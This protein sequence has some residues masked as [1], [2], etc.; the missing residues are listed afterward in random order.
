M[1]KAIL[2][3][4]TIH[5]ITGLLV[6]LLT[7]LAEKNTLIWLI[8]GG[9]LFA[10]VTFPLKKFQFLHKT[11]ENSYG[12]LFYPLGVLSAFL[13]LF[14]QPIYLF[15]VSI[16]LLTVSDTLAN[17]L[18][19]LSS[20][21]ITFRIGKDIKSINGALA[22][23][24]SGGL[25]LLAFFPDFSQID[26]SWIFLLLFGLLNF[27]LISFK[28]SDNLTIPLGS[29]ILLMVQQ[30]SVS[31]SSHL[32][33]T[34]TIIAIGSIF[35][36]KMR[37][38]SRYGSLLAY[39]LGIYFA[40]FHNFQWILP[41]LFFLITSV[42]FTRLNHKIRKKSTDSNPRNAWQVGANILPAIVV[43]FAYFL[44]GIEIFIFF[45]ISLIAAVTA[46]TWASELGPVF[47]K[48][49]FSIAGFNQAEAGISGGVSLAGSIIALVASTIV[50]I[51]S[52]FIFFNSLNLLVIV[53]IS[54]SGFLASFA[55]S[56]LGAFW[57]PRLLRLRFFN[58][59]NSNSTEKLTPNDL[60]N[61]V[62]SATAPLFLLMLI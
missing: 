32:P 43:S 4:K 48:T 49:C 40:T 35:I 60:V 24:I 34:L 51:L 53:L 22:F 6:F 31:F 56:L 62:G 27:E 29:A 50:S 16:L 3:R 41:V 2:R 33:F 38:L 59:S 57:E 58:N 10:V 42:I 1:D 30:A 18:G 54:L 13:V 37:V 5:F 47:S 52:Y 55:D 19:S 25:I 9:S 26:I 15:R 28:G 46:D 36:Y 7:Y 12:T 20:K 11:S 23:L 39:L 14:N 45:Y 61:I 17:V 21:N 44:T 8:I